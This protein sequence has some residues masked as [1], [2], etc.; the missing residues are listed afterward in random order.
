MRGF[1]RRAAELMIAP[2]LRLIL[3]VPLLP[4]AVVAAVLGWLGRGVKGRIGKRPVYE[5]IRQAAGYGL[6][7]PGS[8][9]SNRFLP[10]RGHFL[11]RPLARH[12]RRNISTSTQ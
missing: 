6:S 4:L 12:R 11:G 7:P 5:A 3:A 10:A 8:S 2:W 9:H 1:L